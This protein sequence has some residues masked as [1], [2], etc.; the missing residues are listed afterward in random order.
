MPMTLFGEY[1]FYKILSSSTQRSIKAGFTTAHF[2]YQSDFADVFHTILPLI[3]DGSHQSH[4]IVNANGI[5]LR[6]K[7]C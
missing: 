5:A 1:N 7:T 2:L 4:I 3:L 6:A